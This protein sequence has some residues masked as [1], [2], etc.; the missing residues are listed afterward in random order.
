MLFTPEAREA[1][2]GV[3]IKG[4]SFKDSDTRRK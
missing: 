3:E 4:V 1:L 2:T